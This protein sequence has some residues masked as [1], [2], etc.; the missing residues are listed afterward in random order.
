MNQK[1]KFLS[2]VIMIAAAVAVGSQPVLAKEKKP[3]ATTITE[4]AK[5]KFSE[6][7]AVELKPFGIVPEHAD[8]KGNQKSAAVM[9][10]LLQQELRILFPNLKV[11][12]A[13]Q[14]F[15][16]PKERT[17]QIEPYISDIRKV[18]TGAR[19][20]AGAMA[21]SSYVVVQVTYR[22]SSTGEVI[23]RPQFR[24][25]VSGWTDAWGE[26]G[27]Q[28]RDQLCRDIANYTAANK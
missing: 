2:L 12:G 3:K 24:R 5:V 6:F 13:G 16:K 7:Q 22:D 1:H 18:S 21:G 9:D 23:A 10:D 28:L 19:V 14:D 25:S 4:P 26:Q 11:L 27:N 15:S 17:L 20:W 8:H